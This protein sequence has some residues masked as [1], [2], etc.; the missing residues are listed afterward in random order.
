MDVANQHPVLVSPA[1]HPDAGLPSPAPGCWLVQPITQNI[2]KHIRLKKQTQ[3][4]RQRDW[5]S[6][7]I[8]V[9][10]VLHSPKTFFTKKK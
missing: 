7:P 5:E 1:Q 4:T 8:A 9:S 3:M 10:L 6:N 2:S